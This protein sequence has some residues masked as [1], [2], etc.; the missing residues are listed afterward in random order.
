MPEFLYRFRSAKSLLG[1]YQELEQQ[2]IYFAEPNE[3]ND[4]VE[5]FKDMFW[6]GDE[7]IWNNFLRH[8]LLCLEHASALFF[9]AGENSSLEKASYIPIFK[10]KQDFPTDEYACLYQEVVD[11]FFNNEEIRA[12][13]KLLASRSG[14]IRQNE[15]VFH[16]SLIHLHALNS[17]F[18][19]YKNHKFITNEIHLKSTNHNIENIIRY[20][21]E[22]EFTYS[23]VEDISEKIFSIHASFQ[24]Q[25]E[26]MFE[27]QNQDLFKSKRFLFFS[28]PKEFIKQL[29]NLA[30]GEWYT[31]CFVADCSNPSMW[32]YYGDNH[33]GVCLKFKTHKTE[34]NVNLT[35][36]GLTGESFTKQ[37][38]S[39]PI[40]NDRE[41]TFHR[42][43]YSDKYPEV[44]FFKSIGRLPIPILNE[45]WYY[46]KDGNRSICAEELVGSEEK[47][48]DRYWKNFYT[49]ITTK[50][51][52]W[53]HE[54]EYRL[55][56][57]PML[58]DYSQIERRKLKYNFRRCSFNID[59]VS[60][61]G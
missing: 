59:S 4:P 54:E 18:L 23:D 61:P 32:G 41:Y 17:I 14:K 43:S 15:L 36:H 45:N 3:L 7:I 27:Y 37:A 55:I 29:Y 50:L 47:W 25:N 57:S 9:I 10:T 33:K 2:E 6:Q 35:L 58:M 11:D 16:L 56:I 8:Y 20:I 60:N 52:H 30:Y 44:D 13:P 24:S 1:E 21:N 46:D 22:S 53:S 28:F 34:D 48:R 51:T 39:K 40:F 38:G 26:L 42:I 19:V 31:A 12:Y 49:S 5:G